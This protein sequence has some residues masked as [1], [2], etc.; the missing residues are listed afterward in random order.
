MAQVP[1]DI[2]LNQLEILNGATRTN[3]VKKS[4]FL[5]NKSKKPTTNLRQ[6][7]LKT[8]LIFLWQLKLPL[9]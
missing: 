1:R 5:Q 2:S 3:K 8:H 4:E 6:N 7:N 9:P